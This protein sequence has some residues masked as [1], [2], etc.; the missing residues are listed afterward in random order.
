MKVFKCTYSFL[1][2]SGEWFTVGDEVRC[3]SL[4]HLPYG[5]RRFFKEIP[6]SEGEVAVPPEARAKMQEPRQQPKGR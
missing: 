5:Q 1:A 3:A 2:P 6:N 4:E